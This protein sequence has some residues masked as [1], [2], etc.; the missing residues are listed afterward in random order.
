MPWWHW[1]RMHDVWASRRTGVGHKTDRHALC[2]H[3]RWSYLGWTC[4][5]RTSLLTLS[6]RSHRIK[7]ATYSFSLTLQ[8]CD[9]EI[10]LSYRKGMQRND[11]KNAVACAWRHV[12]DRLSR[13][14][15]M[16]TT[17]PF[18]WPDLNCWISSIFLK[19]SKY[20]SNFLAAVVVCWMRKS[21]APENSHTP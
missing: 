2:T 21:V 16:L 15:K 17:Y 19:Y 12:D 3:H 14:T 7:Y 13:Q 1:L 6:S 5:S 20:I 10:T 4:S 8:V 11:V 9:T 18:R